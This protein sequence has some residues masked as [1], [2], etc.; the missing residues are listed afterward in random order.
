MSPSPATAVLAF[1][2][3]VHNATLPGL[4]EQAVAALGEAGDRL[5]VDLQRTT[6]LCSG[7]LGLLVKLGKRLHDR[8]GALAL[9]RPKPPIAKLLR[10]VGLDA[11]LPSFPGIEAATTHVSRGREG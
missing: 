2:E 7:G 8:G 5:V 10:A 4:E 1:P 6:F 3:E 11:L 9:A